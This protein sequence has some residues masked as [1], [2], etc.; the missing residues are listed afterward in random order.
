MQWH[1]TRYVGHVGD[2]DPWPCCEL[3]YDVVYYYK[4]LYIVSCGLISRVAW[5]RDHKGLKGAKVQT[6]SNLT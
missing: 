5:H 2:L 4:K 6:S 3:I 1:I